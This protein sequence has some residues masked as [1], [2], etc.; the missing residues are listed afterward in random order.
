MTNLFSVND[1]L[2]NKISY[3][4]LMF[5]MASL[6]FDMFYSHLILISYA[7]H[8]LIHLKKSSFKGLFTLRTILLQS[9]FYI[10]L[11][12]TIYTINPH[13]AF[14]DWGKHI[15]IFLFPIFFCLNPLDIKKYKSQLLLSFSLVCTATIIYL[16]L[17]AL[18]TIRHYYLPYSIILSGVFTNHNFSQPI[19]MHATFFSMQLALALVYI[20]SVLIKEPIKYKRLFYLFCCAVLSAG[21]IQLCSK[22]VFIALIIII[23][24]AV[25]YYLLQGSK[26][27]H[28][29]FI[30][31]SLFFLLLIAVFN[32]KTLRERYVTQLREDLSGQRVDETTDGRLSRWKVAIELIE[33]KPVIGYGAGSEIG[34]LQDSFFNNKL[35]S[36][37]LNRLNTHNQYLSFLLK[38][39]IIGLSI[40]LVTLAFG[41][42]IAFRRKDILF[43]TFMALIAIVSMSED[44]LDVDKGIFFYAYFFSFFTFSLKKSE[45]ASFA[46]PRRQS[47]HPS[48][49]KERTLN[50][51]VALTPS[52]PDSY[53]EERAGVRREYLTELATK[54]LIAPS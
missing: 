50:N 16:Y 34:L 8:T 51:K 37:Y 15:A 52:P 43:I 26:R 9:V 46:S 54:L 10:T 35:Y 32:S 4:H 29:I 30:S 27:R 21:L 42:D 40:Y 22:S 36:S 13:E 19:G 39:G 2:P 24:I 47:P 20:L 23:N 7:L 41:F 1:S 31:S 28:F 14:N 48:S 11:L 53:R 45:T 3:Y 12:S 49:P 17:D 38:S 18:I 5:L 33:R 25:P 44:F 6:P